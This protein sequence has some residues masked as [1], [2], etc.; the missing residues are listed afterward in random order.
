MKIEEI[1]DKI[2]DNLNVLEL[3]CK[4]TE[5][6]EKFVKK[7]CKAIHKKGYDV[8]YITGKDKVYHLIVNRRI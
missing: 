7:V 3:D 4:S 5:N 6:P 8:G 2:N 1:L